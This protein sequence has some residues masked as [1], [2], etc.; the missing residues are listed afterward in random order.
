MR[1][2]GFNILLVNYFNS[3]I[4]G[5]IAKTVDTKAEDIDKVTA[6]NLRGVFLGTKHVLKVMEKQGNGSFINTSSI[7]R[8][9][10]GP[11]RIAYSATKHAVVGMTKTAAL[12]VV[13][14]GMRVNSI[15]P[16]YK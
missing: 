4:V 16:S 12:E 3:G 15:H 8:L 10:G 1:S 13:E 6:V 9:A 2:N 11:G 7:D 14:K 5:K